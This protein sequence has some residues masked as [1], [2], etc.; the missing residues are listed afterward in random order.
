MSCFGVKYFGL[1]I[2]GE[3]KLMD[4]VMIGDKE[5]LHKE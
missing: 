3:A 1:Q 4:A 2:A 5:L